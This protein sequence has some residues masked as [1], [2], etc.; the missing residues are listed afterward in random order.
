MKLRMIKDRK[1]QVSLW[2]WSRQITIDFILE[3]GSKS[4]LEQIADMQRLFKDYG[5]TAARLLPIV[6]EDCSARG[7]TEVYFKSLGTKSV[8]AASGRTASLVLETPT[9]ASIRPRRWKQK[10][11]GRQ[12]ADS[13]REAQQDGRK[14]TADGRYNKSGK[15]YKRYNK[16]SGT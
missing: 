13:R 14:R 4:T 16:K 15:N 1:K 12:E 11:K 5:Q 6:N 10:L 3:D 9:I 8:T 2:L 7:I